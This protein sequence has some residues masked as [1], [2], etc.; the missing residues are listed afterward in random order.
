MYTLGQSQYFVADM[1]S[2]IYYFTAGAAAGSASA[3]RGENVDSRIYD[4]VS[5]STSPS[6]ISSA[7]IIPPSSQSQPHTSTHSG[8]FD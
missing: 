3:G 8:K 4:A 7:S 6:G 1:H 2:Q 5:S